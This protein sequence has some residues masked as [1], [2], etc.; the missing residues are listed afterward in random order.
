MVF[1]PARAEATGLS[2]A[3]QRASGPITITAGGTYSGI[4]ESTT[5]APAV[6]IATTQ[7]VT[8]VNSVIRNLAGGPL[9]DA[10]AAG[11][12]QVTVDH[13]VAYGGGTYR[14]S[15]RFFQASD[16]KSIR[17]SN[18]TIENTLGIELAGGVAGSSVVITRNKHRNIQGNGTD[19]VGNFVQFRVVQDATIDVSWN[20]IVNEYN[21]SDPEDIISLYHTSN[22]RVHDNMLWHQSSPG[23]V[24]GSSQ[25]GITIDCSDV[26]EDPCNHNVIA[27]NQVVDGMGI[28]T[29]V[30]QGGSDNLLVD[31]RVVGDGRLPTGQRIAN[32]WLACRILPGGSNNRAQGNVIGYINRDGQRSDGRFDGSPDGSAAEWKRNLHMPGRITRA[33]EVREWRLWQAKLKKTKV[34]LGA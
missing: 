18:C 4:W 32:G 34:R 27:R 2:E 21:K 12:V 7:P 25:G 9:I 10:A 8:I 6:R 23:N 15:G 31:N 33:S 14:T 20:E 16:F 24:S 3:A 29:Y 22:A 28:V 17:I 11:A 5:S 30:T 13:V 1:S 19:P 26:A